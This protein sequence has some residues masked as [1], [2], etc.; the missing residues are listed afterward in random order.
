MPEPITV[1]QISVVIPA[2]NEA[3]YIAACIESVQRAAA[4]LIEPLPGEI[5]V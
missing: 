4:Q 2:H 3:R 1:N 5:I